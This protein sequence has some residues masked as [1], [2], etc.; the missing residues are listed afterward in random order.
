MPATVHGSP[1]HHLLESLH[2]APVTSA[3]PSVAAS[4]RKATRPQASFRLGNRKHPQ[5]KHG[6]RFP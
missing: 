6:L 1:Q 4:Q 5:G 3:N 2:P